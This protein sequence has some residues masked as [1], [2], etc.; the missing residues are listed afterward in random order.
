MIKPNIFKPPSE[1]EVRAQWPEN[2]PLTHQIYERV[3]ELMEKHRLTA[4]E[5]Y[6]MINREDHEPDH[7]WS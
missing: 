4:K 2:V 6:Q 3:I 7:P 1:E 5:A